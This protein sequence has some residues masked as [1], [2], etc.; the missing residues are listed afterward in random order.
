MKKNLQNILI[1]I[2]IAILCTVSC[3]VTVQY[4]SNLYTFKVES[5]RESLKNLMN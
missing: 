5:I 3:S 2:V 1:I 4:D